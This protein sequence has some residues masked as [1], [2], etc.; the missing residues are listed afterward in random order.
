MEF[1]F[2]SHSYEIIQQIGQGSF[3]KVYLSRCILNQKLVAIKIIDLEVCKIDIK[4]FQKG[5][6]F[7]LT[8]NHKNLIKYYGS[9]INESELWIITEFLDGGSLYDILKYQYPTGFHD[10]ILLA[11]IFEPVLNFLIY[12]HENNQIHRDIRTGNILINN[13][14]DIKVGD[15]ALSGGSI[16]TK[17]SPMLRFSIIGSPCYLAPEVMKENIYSEKADI[18]SLGI[19]LYE[20]AFGHPPFH[21]L[22]PQEQ[23]KMIINHPPNISE[24]SG[25]SNHF[26]KFINSCLDPNPKTRSSAKNL[27][28]SSFIKLSKSS[29]YLSISL[30]FNLPPLYQRFEKCIY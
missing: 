25:F 22:Q 21:D 14:G 20:L 10:E 28:N 29:K 23:V 26:I 4:T 3:G 7:W 16:Q 1:P 2:D 27:I 19:C 13:E 17:D 6:S 11:S 5:T 8:S 9:F 24:N 18:W 12:F 15:L 30:M